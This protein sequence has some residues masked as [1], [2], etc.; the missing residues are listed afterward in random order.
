MYSIIFAFIYLIGFKELLYKHFYIFLQVDYSSPVTPRPS[1][2]HNGTVQRTPRASEYSTL[3]MGESKLDYTD[4][5]LSLME[6]FRRR[7]QVKI[8]V[9]TQGRQ[10]ILYV[11]QLYSDRIHCYSYV[12]VKKRLVSADALAFTPNYTLGLDLLILVEGYE[13]KRFER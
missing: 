7:L 12:K 8:N 6:K 1:P 3:N 11:Q 9:I 10:C 5:N 4:P 13:P 2:S